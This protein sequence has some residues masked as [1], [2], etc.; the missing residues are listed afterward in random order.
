MALDTLP[1]NERIA[2]VAKIFIQV[3]GVADVFGLLLVAT[4]TREGPILPWA[5]GY[6]SPT[7]TVGQSPIPTRL[8]TGSKFRMPEECRRE[9][10]V[11]NSKSRAQP[12]GSAYGISSGHLQD[13][14][15]RKAEGPVSAP[16]SR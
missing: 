1:P 2:E 9:Y 4:L 13:R 11:H 3:R 10:V 15:G 8:R 12:R 5:D 7:I 14:D 16:S 6:D